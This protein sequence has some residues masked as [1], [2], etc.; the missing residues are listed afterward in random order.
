MDKVVKK[1]FGKDLINALEQMIDEF[2]ELEFDE[3]DIYKS[4]KDIN[5]SVRTCMYLLAVD[6]DKETL[7]FK[8]N[9]VNK[10]L[11][12]ERVSAFKE[13][14]DK[15]TYKKFLSTLSKVDKRS[16]LS[17]LGLDLDEEKLFSLSKIK[18]VYYSVINESILEDQKLDQRDGIERFVKYKKEGKPNN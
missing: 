4:I 17:D 13:S 11:K 2:Y 16:L 6:E 15:G 7:A 9:K 8:I 3:K 10:R 1:L 18:K 5:E 12:D 14:F